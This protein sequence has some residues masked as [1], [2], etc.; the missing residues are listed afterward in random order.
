LA[1]QITIFS[2]VKIALLVFN[3]H[4]YCLAFSNITVE[5][6]KFL[7]HHLYLM[8]QI[9]EFQHKIWS[10]KVG[11]PRCLLRMY[12]KKTTTAQPLH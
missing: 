2:K 9:T 12:G 5:N 8:T 3:Y 7:I 6:C 1:L 4:L 10:Q 11:L